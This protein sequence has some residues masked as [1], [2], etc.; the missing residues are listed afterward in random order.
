MLYKT[1]TVYLISVGKYYMKHAPI[2]YT[3]MAAKH[4]IWCPGKVTIF[5]E[6]FL[7]LQII[8]GARGSVVFK[9]LCTKPQGRGFETQ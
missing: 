8:L 1:G 5:L 2:F 3:L 4:S 6:L 7:R 9:A